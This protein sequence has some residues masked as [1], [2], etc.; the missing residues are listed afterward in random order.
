MRP[1][2]MQ[3]DSLLLNITDMEWMLPI[4]FLSDPFTLG[5]EELLC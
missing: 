5:K 2:I 1:G 3:M 4:I